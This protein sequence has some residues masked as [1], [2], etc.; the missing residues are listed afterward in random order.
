MDYKG[1]VQ[2]L[3]TPLPSFLKIPI[4]K[5]LGAKI[6]KGVVISPLVVL[7]AKNINLDSNSYI[8]PLTIISGLTELKLGAYAGISNLCVINGTDSLNLG[9]RSFIS[10]GC[11]IDVHSEIIIGEYSAIGPRST[12][13][14]HGIFFPTSWGYSK[15]KEAL[16]IGDLVWISNNCKIGAGVK[17]VSNSFI[18]PNSMISKNIDSSAI[19]FD[20]SINRKSFPIYLVSRKISKKWIKEYIKR[21]I[22]AYYED[23]LQ[24]LG[25]KIKE[26]EQQIILVR[27]H[28]NIV[29]HLFD[30]PK[31]ID[32]IHQNWYFSFN[33]NNE[34]FGDNYSMQIIDFLKLY[35]SS[36]INKTFNKVLKY[37][38]HEWVLKIA[39]IKYKNR[40]KLNPP[41]VEDIDD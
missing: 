30:K 14:T 34:I 15:K 1:I 19:I 17:I 37:L 32:N 10:A 9:P 22:R 8:K 36:N 41:A 20:D 5:L 7:L 24:N 6:G 2:L 35:H 16:E 39:D 29:I 23:Q 25:Y 12:I 28:K 18:L 40:F 3:L 11:M 4:L 33:L 13:M 38:Y 21:V 26:Y 27:K 31:D